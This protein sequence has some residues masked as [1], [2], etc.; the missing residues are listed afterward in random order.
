MK[1]VKGKGRKG[2]VWFGVGNKNEYFTDGNGIPHCG[3]RP[4]WYSG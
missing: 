1:R 3:Y 4:P 2:K